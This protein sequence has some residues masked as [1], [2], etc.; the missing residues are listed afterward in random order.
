MLLIILPT[1]QKVVFIV[2]F[3]NMLVGALNASNFSVGIQSGML[4]RFGESGLKD[5]TSIDIS[6][7]R[8]LCLFEIDS[9][10]D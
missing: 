2:Q 7:D 1:T 3:E 10:F 5:S 8:T 4:D 6:V 9:N